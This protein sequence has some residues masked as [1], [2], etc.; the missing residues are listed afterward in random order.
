MKKLP[1]ILILC[2]TALLLLGSVTLYSATMRQPE[3][4][5]LYAHLGWIALGLAVGTLAAL[6]PYAW[7]RRWHTP[8]MLLGIAVVLLSL[9]FVPGISIRTNGACRWLPFG[10]PSEFAKLALIVALAHYIATRPGHMHERDAGFLCPGTMAGIV[11][12][13][14]F[15][16]PDWGSAALMAAVTLALLLVG[17]AHWFYLTSTVIIGGE[18]FFIMLLQ[19]QLRLTRVI[20]F[21]DPEHYQNGVAWQ[22]WHSLLSLGVGGWLGTFF[23]EGSHKF[24]FV[25][26]QQ[27]DFILSLIGEELGLFGTGLIVLFF[28]LIVLC[29]ARIAWRINDPFAQLLAVGITLLIGLQA[30]INVA[31]VTSSLP[32]K[33]LPLPFVSYGGSNLVCML[34][35]V[36]LLVNVARR[37]PLAAVDP[38]W[39]GIFAPASIKIGGPVGSLLDDPSRRT[40]KGFWQKMITRLRAHLDARFSTIP[41]HSYQRP[42]RPI[43]TGTV[44]MKEAANRIALIARERR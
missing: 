1:L 34:T 15:L 42:P 35:G 19:N 12:L 26:E 6:I 31:V 8:Y 21:L 23:G 43:E 40:R 10:Q 3:P 17:G 9:V 13:L 25:P 4:M 32:N 36:G 7:L 16:E 29:G 38:A 41:R 44:E 24:G 33:G 28:C 27:T 11:C 37:A 5:R 2:V 39:K 14:I 30:F 22:G 20:S 18:A